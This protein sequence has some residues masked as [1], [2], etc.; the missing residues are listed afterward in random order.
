V[1]EKQA[2]TIYAQIEALP[3]LRPHTYLITNYPSLDDT[4]EKWGGADPGG[5][6]EYGRWVNGGVWTTLEARTIMAYYRLGKYEDV[7]RSAL[8]SRQFAADYQFDAPLKNFG[9]DP[10]FDN[11]PT[12]ICYD[13]LGVPAAT[14]RGLFEY[15]YKA[16]RLILRPR[17]PPSVEQYSQLEPVR[18]GSKLIYLSVKNGGPKVGSVKVNGKAWKVGAS[19]EVVLP[20]DELPDRAEVKISMTGGWPSGAAKPTTPPDSEP[21]AKV[22]Q[23]SD[24]PESLKSKYQELVDAQKKLEAMP[25]REYEKA[26]VAEA[27]S[28]FEAW[29]GRADIQ[30]AGAEKGWTRKKQA[31]V[32]KMHRDAALAMYDGARNML[33]IQGL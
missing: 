32:L 20:Y 28:A 13:A 18:F 6:W 7:R 9:K 5:L 10:W 31:A 27:I 30:Y 25:G 33:K 21:A 12:N 17:I 22:R 15:V 11:Q 2:E 23:V 3:Q 1:D 26:F 24:F 29:R 16:D 14:A 19:D 8:T 4:Y